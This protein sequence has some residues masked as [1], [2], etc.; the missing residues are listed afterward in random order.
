MLTVETLTRAFQEFGLQNRPVI[1]HASLKSFGFVVGGAQSIVEALVNSTGGLVMPTHTYAALVSPATGPQLNGM[2]YGRPQAWHRHTEPYTPNLPADTLMGAIPEALRLH[3][4]AQ[5]SSHPVL[6]FAGIH[7]ENALGSQ[8]LNN[9]FA[10]LLELAN[11]DGWCLLLG[12]DHTVN[13]SIHCAEKLAGRKQ[14]IRWAWT[15]EGVV[16]FQGFPSCS[17]NFELIEPYM[18]PYTREAWV[19][20]ARV[21]AFPLRILIHETIKLIRADPEALLCRYHDCN[22]C[23]DVREHLRRARAQK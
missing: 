11:Q 1:A 4:L 10:P 9:P 13:T 20:A 12:V 19:G 18:Q 14:F 21:R 7:A 6:S 2:N 16:S 5:R 23:S 8:T 22:R 3:P 15:M 17:T